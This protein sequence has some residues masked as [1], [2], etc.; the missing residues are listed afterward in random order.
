MFINMQK[1]H[2]VLLLFVVKVSAG[3]VFKSECVLSPVS[4]E[5]P[6]QAFLGSFTVLSGC[7]SRGTRGLPH[8]VHIINLRRSEESTSH[9]KRQVILHLTP[10]MAAAVHS[11]PLVFVLNSPEPTKWKLKTKGL[12]LGVQRYFY[13]SKGSNVQFET[14]DFSSTAKLEEHNMPHDNKQLL[15]WTQRKFKRVTS[16]TE[17]RVCENIYVKVGEDPVFPATCVIE[18]NFLS[19]NYLGEYLQPQ[20]ARGCI[21]SH[22]REGKQVHIIDLDYPNA[23]SYSTFQ[24]DII[25]DI[26]Q[27]QSDT[28]LVQDLVLILKCMNSVNWVIKSRDVKGTLEVITPNSLTFDK[29]PENFLLGTVRY[30]DLPSHQN[31][32][33]W[34]K[35]N[36]YSPVATYTKAPVANRFQIRLTE[37]ETM[38]AGDP[39]DFP[40]FP[41]FR[42]LPPQIPT[43]SEDIGFPFSLDPEL[44]EEDTD[45]IQ[46]PPDALD[47]L[48]RP[49]I[50]ELFR[51][52]VETEE[53]QGNINMALSVKCEDYKILVTVEKS[54]LQ[55]NGYM[56]PELSLLHPSCKAK[57]NATHYILETSL[58][59]CGTQLLYSQEVDIYRNF[60]VI[61]P[62][63]PR[64]GSGWSSDYED[65]ESGDHGFT[66]DMDETDAE[67]SGSDTRKVQKIKFNCT[68]VQEKEE[69][70]NMSFPWPPYSQFRDAAFSMDL[71]DTDRFLSPAQGLFPVF[72]NGHIYVEVSVNKADEDLGF[73]I[74]TC[75][76]S[77]YSDSEVITEYTIIENICPK[78]ESVRF[79]SIQKTNFPML[80][81]ETDKKRF[82]FEFKPVFNTSLLFLHCE[83]SL[84][85]RKQFYAQDLPKCI[86]P[87]EA[88]DTVNME[89]LLAMMMNK[90]T[91]TKALAVMSNGTSKTTTGVNQM[92]TVSIKEPP[93]PPAPYVILGLDTP[94]VVGIAFAAFVIGALLTGALWYIYSHTGET[95]GRQQ[96][97]VM[98]P[99]S[100]NSSA[101]HSTG[102][103]QSTPCSS[104]STA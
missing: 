87:D 1:F 72:E 90:K 73:L 79:Y 103:T 65:M 11:K 101:A 68:Y 5:Y 32:I 37:T 94:T 95:Q 10:I 3:P 59:D 23:N 54:S 28:M 7:A 13:V 43:L 102:S 14:A 20:P 6:V 60:V 98:P 47:R 26:R 92:P 67:P 29:D 49:D 99:A 39:T 52:S 61:Q 56:V 16:F 21:L 34:A 74:Q 38:E 82:S 18:N 84:C 70:S 41:N 35:S 53:A 51:K 62:T 91:F 86:P 75:F 24:V 25:I 71:Y 96:V 97:P 80:H 15:Q 100:E 2:I 69:T 17:L 64:D 9:S 77:N 104:S 58:N 83:L 85:S 76:I 31:L 22:H 12:Q 50:E 30:S 55:G 40:L 78:D 44:Y 33:Q 36:G 57:A 81:T 46:P 45:V 89:M 93:P 27:L 63:S 8:E 88:C 42:A 48:R 19:L 4:D 66:A